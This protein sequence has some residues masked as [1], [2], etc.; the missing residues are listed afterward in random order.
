MKHKKINQNQIYIEE[1]LRSAMKFIS[2][3]NDYEYELKKLCDRNY[4]MELYKKYPDCFLGV[5]RR[6][7][8]IFPYFYM[9]NSNGVIDPEII[10]FSLKLAEKFKEKFYQKD[11][12]YEHLEANIRKMRFYLARYNKEIPKSPKISARLGSETKKLNKFKDYKND[13]INGGG[14]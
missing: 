2:P 10:K 13:I 3:I 14:N 4:R 12:D 1:L 9:C 7:G 11:I 5:K 6:C 8:K